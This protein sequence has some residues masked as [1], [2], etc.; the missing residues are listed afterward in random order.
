[1]A[2]EMDH[3][4]ECF[5]VYDRVGITPATRDGGI[6]NQASATAIVSAASRPRESP[7]A[8]QTSNRAFQAA[9]T[10]SRA[11]E[12]HATSLTQRVPGQELRAITLVG[13]TADSTHAR[14]TS[15]AQHSGPQT[16]DCPAKMPVRQIGDWL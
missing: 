1:M 7:P 12:L 15:P 6:T 13:F 4:P 2:E 3:H 11:T 5:N 10:P 14:K 16:S 8:G 9:R